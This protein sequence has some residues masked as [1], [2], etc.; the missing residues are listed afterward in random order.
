[1]KKTIL[2]ILVLG[3][4]NLIKAQFNETIRTGRPGQAI[5]PFAVGAGVFQTQT[6][7]DFGGSS[8]D[9]SKT[10]SSY[11]APNTVLRLGLTD[12]FE[13]NT[14]LEYRNDSYSFNKKELTTNGLSLT[15]IGTRINLHQSENFLPNLGV[16][17]TFKLPFLAK[18][19]NPDYVAPK[20]MLIA[21]KNLSNKFS[22]LLNT[23]INYNG[24]DAKP[25]GVY[26][27]NLGYSFSDKS[28]TF[29]ENYGSFNS[30]TYE[31][32]WDTGLYY[33]VN[34]NLQLD[35]YGGFGKNNNVLDHFVSL[36]FSWRVVTS[37][38][39]TTNN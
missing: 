38:N 23:G 22:F 16:Q 11:F 9:I 34:T 8:N 1:M 36:G 5:G 14:G 29:V 7:F 3:L 4:S 32:R 30:S 26:V 15:S 27:L 10:G 39:K 2:L 35:L 24:N 28:G 37:K 31:N 6:G 17:L 33:L 13:I 25:I 19:Y 12:R 21:S 18:A 20:I